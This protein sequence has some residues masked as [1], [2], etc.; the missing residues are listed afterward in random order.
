[1]IRTFRPLIGA[2][3]GILLITGCAPG[4]VGVGGP[5]ILLAQQPTA[6]AS[7]VHAF[8]LPLI[9]GNSSGVPITGGTPIPPPLATS[10]PTLTPTIPPTPT[11]TPTPT[12][13]PTPIITSTPVP[14]GKTAVL[15]AAGDI[16]RCG[17]PGSSETAAIISK[18]PSALLAPLGD[19][20]YESGTLTEY[21]TCYDPVWGQFNNRARP[22]VGN[23]EYLTPGAQGYFAYFGAVAGDPTKGYYSYNLGSWH[24]VVLNSEC[25]NAGGCGVKSP[26]ETWLSADLAAHPSACTLAYFHEPYFNSGY[27]GQNQFIAPLVT[28]LYNA[29][30]ELMLSGHAHDYER[31]SPQDPSGNLDTAKGI[32]Q[33]VVGTGGS[34]FTPLNFP[35]MPNS[36][37]SNDTTFGVLK[38]TLNPTSYSFQ[39]LPVAGSTFTDSG[40]GTCH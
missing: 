38:L 30:V 20:A 5:A 11:R 12:L 33:I 13:T 1:M 39:F 3:I 22:A 18:Y 19:N 15:L 21:Q 40:S 25:G 32:V 17:S 28:D 6:N 36:V 8:Y 7:S 16:A 37:T 26:Q 35:L 9:V 10:T 14:S 24:V 2:I 4:L 34:N 23:H 27:G 29:G 31:F